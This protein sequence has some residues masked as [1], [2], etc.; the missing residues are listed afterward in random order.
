M[1][2]PADMK[3]I[4]IEL[5]N[6]CSKRCSNCTR[7]CGHHTEPFFMDF[8]TF[9][10]AVDSMEGFEGIVGI[11]GGEPTIHPEF[12]RFVEY[13]RDHFG[14][15]DR[16]AVCYGP[17][18][19]FTG[20]IL[21]NVY[22]V[23]LSNQRGLWT[24]V[25]AKY[26]EHFEL[27]QDTFG[28]QLVNDH[29]AA[30]MHETL[31]AT[32]KELGIPDDEWF[33]LR[34]ECWIQNLWSASITPKGAFFCE[35]AASMDATLGGPGGWPIEPGWWKR[36]PG[37]F[38][39]QLHWCELC[40]AALPM[41]SRNANEQTDDV[42]PFWLQKLTEINSPKLRKGGV[43][44]FDPK[45]YESGKHQVIAD[46]TPYLDDQER[47]LEGALRGIRPQSVSTVLHCPEDM[48]EEAARH[49]LG[50][51]RDTGHL[52][53]VLSRSASHGPL[54]EAMGLP[55]LLLEGRSGTEALAWIRQETKAKD[56]I[57]VTQGGAPVTGF[58][59]LLDMCVFNPG[60][61]YLRGDQAS[62]Q[63][64]QF[65]NVRASALVGGGDLFD[66]RASFPGRKVVLVASDDPAA[67]RMGR[68]HKVY[69]RG[70]RLVYWAGGRLQRWFGRK[71][72]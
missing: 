69:R 50:S 56:W 3:I 53:A 12:K 24:S 44:V 32:R 68:V 13:F 55:F 4:Q 39:D 23:N 61:L 34:D 45:A 52:E 59:A 51:L 64:M 17:T 47:R 72:A 65:F 62:G 1:K 27:I 42:S 35:I 37:D 58:F 21:S 2:S 7:F 25:G 71:L 60:C 15:D 16:T 43:E 11:M 20:H 38:A 9:K 70:I 8:K 31:M 5:T 28:Y 18:S 63:G 54:A 10:E 14:Y 41:P 6:A 57:L 49:S 29:T 26:Y 36:T 46:A 19:D 33:R 22:N 30:S 40:S 67:Y 66:L 48:S